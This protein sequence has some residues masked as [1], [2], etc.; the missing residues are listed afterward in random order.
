MIKTQKQ[1]HQKHSNEQQNSHQK[2]RDLF[3][4]NNKTIMECI[5]HQNLTKA[6]LN[7]PASQQSVEKHNNVNTITL[8]LV[9]LF[10]VR[11]GDSPNNH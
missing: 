8:Q 9:C 1:S 3:A 10:Q 4:M 6:I 7:S 11:L 5:Q 2:H